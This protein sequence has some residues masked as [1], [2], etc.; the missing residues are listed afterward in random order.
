[1]PWSL[2]TGQ[3]VRDSDALVDPGDRRILA[4]GDRDAPHSVIRRRRS[5][6]DR[7]LPRSRLD[8]PP[9]R[10]AA[11]RGGWGSMLSPVDAWPELRHVRAA[12]TTPPPGGASD[13]PG[14]AAQHGDRCRSHQPGREARPATTD[15]DHRAETDPGR[16]N[17]FHSPCHHCPSSLPPLVILCRLISQ[18]W[19]KHALDLPARTG[20]AHAPHLR[21]AARCHGQRSQPSRR[22]GHMGTPPGRPERPRGCRVGGERNLRGGGSGADDQ[23]VDGWCAHV[24]LACSRTHTEADANRMGASSRRGP[25]LSPCFPRDMPR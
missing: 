24:D 13:P 4:P 12:S 1:M 2:S 8:H 20:R 14:H 22:P 7:S 10:V 15:N 21:V 6:H 25:W 9:C 5:R 18:H 3:G 23:R 16:N 17:A 11:S 19:V